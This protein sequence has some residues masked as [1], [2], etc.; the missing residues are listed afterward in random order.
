MARM[1]SGFSYQDA[2]KL[3]G[4]DTDAAK[5]VD[6]LSSAGVLL[7]GG[8]N[9]IDARSEVVRLGKD[10]VRTVRTRVQ[11]MSRL[12]RTQLLEAAHSIIVV[13]AFFDALADLSLPVDVGLT[14]PEQLG[15]MTSAPG[16]FP[17]TVDLVGE[18][19]R[20]DTPQPS[21][22]WP[23][24]DLVAALGVQYRARVGSFLSFVSGLAGWDELDARRRQA[25]VSSVSEELPGKAVARYEAMYRKLALDCPEFSVWTSLHEHAATRSRLDDLRALLESVASG[26]V[27]DARRSGL[28]K[29]YADV[30]DRPLVETGD[31]PR[32]LVVP[33]L[34]QA[35]VAPLFKVAEVT[36]ED[37]ISFDSW[38]AAVPRRDDIQDFLAGYL[39]SSRA[40]SAPLVVLGQPGSGKSVLTKMVAAL[41]PAS[42]FLPIRVVLR[43][44]P[45][46]ADVQEQIEHAIRDATGERIDWPSLARSAGQAVPVVLL[47]GF[48][49]LLQATGVSRSD[50]LTKISEFQRR[51]RT[52]GRAVIVVVTSRIAV[53]HRARVPEGTTALRLEPFGEAQVAHWLAGWNTANGD[54]FRANALHPLEADVVLQHA[55]LAEQPLLLFMLALYDL[56]GNVLSDGSRLLSRSTLYEGLLRRFARR[57]VSRQGSSLPDEEIE[58][59]VERE[60]GYLSIVAF[61]MFNRGAQ[62]V[63][64]TSL[65]EDLEALFGAAEPE[66]GVRAHLTA[67]QLVLGR[68]FFVHEACATR[69]DATLQTYE[70]LHA[71]FGEYLV[72]RLIHQ[73]LCDLA[74]RDLAAPSS[75]FGD[76][77]CDDGLLHALLSFAPLTTRAPVM[78]ALRE[79]SIGLERRQRDALRLLLVRL[80]RAAQLPRSD[81]GY[82]RYS[83][84]PM[85]VPGRIAAYTANLALLIVVIGGEL[86]ST[87]LGDGD[88]VREWASLTYLWRSQMSA[89]E[90]SAFAARVDVR[91]GEGRDF[92]FGHAR[93][94]NF[95]ETGDL[96]HEN[97]IHGAGVL[98]LAAHAVLPV[99][100][101][102]GQS[103][104]RTTP[105]GRDFVSPVHLLMDA[106]AGNA[107]DSEERNAKY[108]ACLLAI[109]DVHRYWEL[110]LRLIAQD[111]SVSTDVALLALFAGLHYG[112]AP[113][114][115][116]EVAMLLLE[117]VEHP[118]VVFDAL[119]RILAWAELEAPA[120]VAVRALVRLI[121]LGLEDDLCRVQYLADPVAFLNHG[122]LLE[123]IAEA[124]PALYTRLQWAMRSV[125][126]ADGVRWL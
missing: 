82:P 125:G 103:M 69:D 42:D 53:A 10:L 56:E 83:P 108:Q 110:L 71:T 15:V 5:L 85:T 14:R 100:Y 32:D 9:L 118:A 97:T 96:I 124:D 63:D 74:E 76:G 13:T 3:L 61:A 92:A 77:R 36:R 75:P 33:P 119:N 40:V 37:D 95:T 80:L 21:A 105:S 57:E 123:K 29:A 41:L 20:W 112:T 30:L 54:Y 98:D 90:W 49:E 126:L 50:Y 102:L 11:G 99:S 24:A 79:L 72:A 46:E 101:A 59:G 1:R 22:E 66:R 64:E 115:L 89:E 55:D 2:V 111:E 34:R 121:E 86:R 93:G 62:W 28:A 38:W 73:V 91:R 113:G 18:L 48:D 67:A 27:P 6:R 35:Y 60:L 45:A 39:T 43:D 81:A 106:W 16:Q 109:T 44:V 8:V 120:L 23:F 65:N 88:R 87:D 78:T 94:I 52:Q 58:R 26:D 12:D 116:S 47:D 7:T 84:R 104:N 107:A 25:F 70:F 19:L 31:L 4:G 17:R 114:P 68:F 117:R 51:E 122:V